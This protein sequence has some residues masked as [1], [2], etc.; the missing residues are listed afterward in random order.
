M[1]YC[2]MFEVYVII[3]IQLGGQMNSTTNAK[4]GLN[5]I[6]SRV[7][8]L[9]GKVFHSPGLHQEAR[10][11]HLAD[12]DRADVQ[13]LQRWNHLQLHPNPKRVSGEVDMVLTRQ[14][15][16]HTQLLWK[17]E[18]SIQECTCTQKPLETATRKRGLRR[19]PGRACRGRWKWKTHLKYL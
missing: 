18:A 12:W 13:L 5:Q 3:V 8:L 2:H 17:T 9:T 19:G 4:V 6:K 10:A 11:S 16:R 1:Y 7:R 14:S 15:E